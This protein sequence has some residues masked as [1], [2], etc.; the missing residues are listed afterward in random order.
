VNVKKSNN[1]ALAVVLIIVIILSVL[2]TI[3]RMKRPRYGDFPE[4]AYTAYAVDD[5]GAFYVFRF[6]GR[7]LRW[8]ITY[9]GKVLKALYGCADCGHKFPAPP[10]V[11]V[12]SCPAC[13]S[14][15]VGG[16]N[17]KNHGP[18]RATRIHIPK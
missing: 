9:Q 12:T 17:E 4:Y 6:Q 13:H 16:Y 3:R 14:P 7:G 10:G 8:P 11:M 2:V 5:A 18:I 1:V 15:N